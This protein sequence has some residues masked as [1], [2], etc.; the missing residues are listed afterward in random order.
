MKELKLQ[1]DRWCG[2]LSKTASAPLKPSKYDIHLDQNV[3]LIVRFKNADRHIL[4][5]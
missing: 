4:Q 1:F 2:L 3:D 5:K